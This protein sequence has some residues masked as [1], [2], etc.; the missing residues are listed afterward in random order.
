MGTRTIYLVRHGQQDHKHNQDD[1]REGRLT[2]LGRQQARSIARRLRGLPIDAVHCSTLWRAEETAQIITAQFPGVRVRRSP[3]LREC[4]PGL[5][6]TFTQHFTQQY[7]AK[8]IEAGLA[9]ARRAFNCYFKRPRGRD[10]H[11]VIVCH[12]NIIRY[13]ICR[14]LGVKPDAWM[15]LDV[16]NCGLCEISIETNGRIAVIS[17]NDTGHLP[18]KLRTFF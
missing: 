14:A 1:R 3:L 8:L 9:Q 7:K 10:R 16:H 13:F 12:G 5:P 17:H 6:S 11:E 18:G 15:N 2:S 4:I